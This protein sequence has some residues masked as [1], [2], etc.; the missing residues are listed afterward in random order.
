MRFTLSSR[1]HGRHQPNHCLG[2][3]QH[4]N[5]SP[6]PLCHDGANRC[7]I[8]HDTCKGKHGYAIHA[9]YKPQTQKSFCGKYNLHDSEGND[10]VEQNKECR[11]PRTSY[12]KSKTQT[13][14]VWVLLLLLYNKVSLCSSGWLGLKLM[15]VHLPEP[16]GALALQTY[17]RETLISREL[18]WLNY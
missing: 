17:P 18:T 4:V 13:L 10:Q 1:I 9:P 16:P 8:P 5:R 11:R 3:Q 12:R 7:N 14:V 15:E 6:A 2:Q